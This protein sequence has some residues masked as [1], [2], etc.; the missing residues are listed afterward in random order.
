V[1]IRFFTHLKKHTHYLIQLVEFLFFP[2]FLKIIT[3]DKKS[4][5]SVKK[6][7]NLILRSDAI[8]DYILSLDA[9]KTLIY[10]SNED[11]ILVVNENLIGFINELGFNV[12]TIGF[13]REKFILNPFY[14][15]KI[16]RKVI[17]YDY[18]NVFYLNYSRE[19][20]GDEIV[21]VANG[22][23]K[24]GWN[25]DIS[26]TTKFL[27][28]FGNKIYSQLIS[29]NIA[30]MHELMRNNEFVAKVLMIDTEKVLRCDFNR[31][32]Q[33]SPTEKICKV[34]KY[35][36]VAP[37]SRIKK[38]MWKIDNFAQVINYVYHEYGFI[39]VLVGAYSEKY[40]F[41]ELKKKIDDNVPMISKFGSYSF[42]EIIFLLKQSEFLLSNDSALVHFAIKAGVKSVTILGGGQFGRFAPYGSLNNRWVYHKMECYNCNWICKYKEFLCIQNI[43]CKQVIRT[44][45]NVLK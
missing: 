35:F 30:N 21:K 38:K 45:K 22:E 5:K 12:K 1:I 20:L 40:L 26:R 14:H 15:F 16:L 29:S 13:N 36:V 43:D 17:S 39:P 6:K 7:Y 31:I 18:V 19:L 2:L 11:T 28:K 9:I 33:N 32:I 24:Y 3:R 23:K 25:G 41:D 10:Y 44:I 27:T 4:I 37:G 8:G 34:T 42:K